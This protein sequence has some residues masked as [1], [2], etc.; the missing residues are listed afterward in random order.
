[1]KEFLCT[2]GIEQ[3]NPGTSTGQNFFKDDSYEQ[4]TSYTPSDGSEIAK[5]NPVSYTHLTL[6]T[7]YSV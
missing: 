5:V 6:P 1:M 7:I 4:I 2:L 3:K